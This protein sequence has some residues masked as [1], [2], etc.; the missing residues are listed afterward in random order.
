M[1][2]AKVGKPDFYIIAD[3]RKRLW[4][5]GKSLP[6]LATEVLEQRHII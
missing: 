4:Q 2:L 1:R 6:D 5:I 3:S